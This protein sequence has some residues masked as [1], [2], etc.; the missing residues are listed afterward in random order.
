MPR[1]IS[2]S[3][4]NPHQDRPSR[5]SIDR[6]K[7]Y[8]RRCGCIGTWNEYTHEAVEGKR[9]EMVVR[10]LKLCIQE[11]CW[12]NNDIDSVTLT[13]KDRSLPYP[14]AV[15]QCLI[16]KLKNAKDIKKEA[17]EIASETRRLLQDRHKLCYPQHNRDLHV[18]FKVTND[19]VRQYANAREAEIVGEIGELIRGSVWQKQ[20]NPDKVRN[21]TTNKVNTVELELLSLGLD[22]KLPI[23]NESLVNI[24]VA[25]QQFEYRYRGQASKPDLHFAKSHLLSNIHKDNKKVLPRRY[26][27][28][29]KSLGENRDVMVLQSDKGKEVVICYR[30]TYLTLVANHFGN[31]D[32][33]QPVDENDVAG[34]D[35]TCMTK[36]FK[37][38]LNRFVLQAPDDQT[39]KLIKSLFP[40][41]R[42]KFPEGRC[43]LKTHKNGVTESHIPVRPIISNSN[44][45]TSVLA[46]YL[47]KNLTKNL[48]IVSD[49]HI[50]S[51]E[52][53]ADFTKG[54][55][56]EGR[57]L[58]LDVE[59]LFTCIP[60]EHIMTF[61]CN[62]SNGW[63]PNPPDFARPVD[64]PV[65]SFG[66]ESKLFCDLVDLCLKY[67]QFH[68]EGNFYRQIHGLFMGSS[69]SP[70]L[71]QM[72]MESFESN[73]YE[74]MIPDDIKATEWARYVDD[75]FLIYEHSEEVFQSFMSQL[76]TLDPYIRFTCEKSK[77]GVEVGLPE[78]AV[79]V[80]PFLDFKVIRF[81]DANTN[82]LSNKLCIH[83]KDC[84]SG[85]YIHSLS[86]QP[87]SIKRS[88]IRNMFLRAYR[89]CDSHFLEE[90]EKRIYNDFSSLGYSRKFIDRA[91]V[92]AREGRTRELRIRAGLEEPKAPREKSHFHI[93]LPYHK[94]VHGIKYRLGSQGVD[95]TFSNRN[96]I[97]S[98]LAY[99]KRHEP[100]KGGVYL[101]R[102][103][104]SDCEEIYV[105]ESMDIPKRLE[106]HE[107]AKTRPSS[108]YYTSA[109]HTGR[110]HDMDTSS[111]RV[112]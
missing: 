81:L 41:S 97:K 30:T 37:D 50:G 25:F 38:E 40:P 2:T 59:S 4:S 108:A 92:S 82:T 71:A 79:E 31:R 11:Q 95:L 72:Y 22:F 52:E 5:T 101:I 24:S 36:D 106:Q 107:G 28:A 61:L 83:R 104:K 33:Y 74:T 53:F 32:L 62:Q 100:T 91:K 68:V 102:C 105:G 78:E 6:A 76:N 15:N 111:M 29:L 35:L 51:T 1:N 26:I 109:K 69:I 60:R 3:G 75:C 34:Y 46:S 21:L 87:I 54:C 55:T 39:K 16:N 43:S 110:S 18:L 93:G 8:L 99:K 58:S 12:N 67:N 45:P 90:E 73:K 42:P 23:G 10:R 103:K 20:V 89:Y 64:P 77:P 98:R 70:P 57:I 48:G 13:A 84:H 14:D 27:N 65:Y 19:K 86:S 88:V 9:I 7:S 44:A 66:I 85:S 47:G 112:A 17:L 96:S 56:T 80:L 49:K 94:S 63:G